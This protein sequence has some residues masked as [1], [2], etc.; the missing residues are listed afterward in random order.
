MGVARWKRFTVERI[1]IPKLTAAKQR[2]YV[3]LMDRTLEAKDADPD[4]DTSDLEDQIDWLVY[5][6]YGLTDDERSAVGRG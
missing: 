6:L 4:A 1:P 3:R 2:P 5:D